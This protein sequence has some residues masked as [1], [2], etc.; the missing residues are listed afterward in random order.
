M[1][2]QHFILVISADINGLN[3]L[4]ER[5]M[6]QERKLVCLITVNTQKHTEKIKAQS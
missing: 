4:I 6:D 5:L 1:A 3:S 2:T